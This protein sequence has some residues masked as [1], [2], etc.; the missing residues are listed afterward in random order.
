MSTGD[1]IFVKQSQFSPDEW[2]VLALKSPTLLPATHTN[3]LVIGRTHLTLIDPASPYLEAQQK[4]EQYLEAR[5]QTG[6]ILDRIVLTHHHPDHIGGVERLIERYQV[7]V[8]AHRDTARR[9]PFTVKHEIEDGDELW[10]G[11]SQVQRLISL[12]TPGHALGHL[13]LMNPDTREAAVGDMVAGEGTI[14]IDPDE[15]DMGV[16]LTQLARLERLQLTALWPSHGPVLS[17]EILGRYRAHRLAREQR[18]L[19]ALSRTEWF[20]IKDIVSQAYDD[21][22]AMVRHGKTGGIAGRSAWAH[23]I[24]LEREGRV[25]GRTSEGELSERAWRLPYTHIE[26][27]QQSNVGAEMERLHEV[28]RMLRARC[29]WMNTQTLLTLKRYLIEETNELLEALEHPF[30]HYEAHQDELGDVLLQIVLHAVLQEEVAHFDLAKVIQGLTDKLIRRHPHVFAGVIAQ[31]PEDVRTLWQQVKRK[32]REQLEQDLNQIQVVWRPPD[33]K[34]P[35]LSRA[36]YLSEEAA[37]FGFDWPDATGAL[38]K[39]LEERDEILEAIMQ[40]ADQ[41]TLGGELGDLLFAVVSACRLLNVDPAQA[42]QST[43]HR[44]EMRIEGMI[45]FAQIRQLDLTKLSLDE[46]ENLWTEVKALK[47]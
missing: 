47:G 18:I 26:Y 4:L 7:E 43:C 1:E 5:F 25:V 42:L 27:A 8:W 46:L 16:Y 11:G 39:V 12:H 9:V 36:L 31:T 41:D 33:P 44:F 28:I 32:E 29:P 35:A 38:D 15:G 30:E 14:L 24:K 23:L 19:N 21:T 2:Q 10:I 34:T 13:C 20:N 17:A 22:P 40:T 6:A 3:C 37:R 45:H